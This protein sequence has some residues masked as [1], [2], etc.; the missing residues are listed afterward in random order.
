MPFVSVH[1]AERAWKVRVKK[2]KLDERAL[3]QAYNIADKNVGKFSRIFQSIQRELIN[4]DV[5][6]Q[7]K[8]ALKE[9]SNPEEIVD[10]IPWYDA[11]APNEYW[12][13]AIDKV[14]QAYA[15]VLTQA[16]DQEAKDVNRQLGTDLT[17]SPKE[18]IS[19]AE[20]II[21]AVPTNP[22]NPASLEWIRQATGNLIAQYI[23]RE[24]KSMVRQLLYD[25][26]ERGERAETIVDRLRQ[27]IGLTTREYAAVNRRRQ[28][29]EQAGLS[30]EKISEK[31]D[32]Y[33]EK[34]RKKRAERIARTETTA[35]QAEGRNQLWQQAKNQGSLPPVV[36]VWV[37]V[38]GYNA[39]GRTCRI[40]NDL[41]GQRR[42]LGESYESMYAPAPIAR[43]PAHP[44]CRCTEILRRSEG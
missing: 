33:A 31:A 44:Y 37:A 5:I 20:N 27:D 41:D 18:D 28:I 13:K 17:F 11:G 35:A 22:V 26:F 4:D 21:S 2:A 7:V 23:T 14:V 24:Q 16:G 34:L 8:A 19:K 30:Q 38:P 29:L 15:D 40:C 3:Q 42:N 6:K 43:P 9:T 39:G 10:V 36:R 1:K 32:K 12:Q 25:A